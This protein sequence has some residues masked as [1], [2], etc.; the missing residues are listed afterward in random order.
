MMEWTSDQKQ[1]ISLRG[2]SLLVAAGAGSGKTAVLVERI[3]EMIS[4]DDP[5][6]IDSLLVVT[7]T[8]AA[9][10][11]MR[12]RISKRIAEKLGE[13]PSNKNL[14][15]QMALLNRANI[16]TMH[17][18]CNRVIVENFQSIDI[19]PENHLMDENETKLLM[20]EALNKVLEE[21]YESGNPDFLMVSD[22][23]GGQRDDKALEKL[24]VDLYKFAMAGPAP[25]EWIN[26][27]STAYDI[28][29]ISGEGAWWFRLLIEE[30]SDGIDEIVDGCERLLRA[31][32]N[33]PELQESK[34]GDFF[35]S[36]AGELAK[37]ADDLSDAG[38]YDGIKELL[39]GFSF[40]R[41]PIVKVTDERVAS[42]QEKIKAL[43]EYYKS[44]F[45]EL[46]DIW[47][48]ESSEYNLK[49]MREMSPVLK[50]LGIAVE[51]F[52]TVYQDLKADKNRMDYND[53][54]H[55][56]LKILCKVSQGEN[57]EFLVEP[58]EAALRY[59]E[60]FKEILVDEYQDSND[61]QET[62]IKAV[63]RDM[64]NVFMVGDVKQS[65]YRFRRAKPQLFLDKY[66][67]YS[68][69]EE[70]ATIGRKVMLFSNFRSRTE[71]LHAV[72][73]IFMRIMSKKAGELDYT[74]EEALTAKADY[75][76][77]K[78]I[79]VEIEIIDTTQNSNESADLSSE[80]DSVN[81]EDLSGLE[82][83]ALHVAS[84]IR[85]MVNFG[86]INVNIKGNVRP[87]KYKDIVILLRSTKNRSEVFEKALNELAIPV[88]SESSGGYFESI[89]IRTMLSL[90][91]T[92][93]NPRQDIPLLSVLR[94]PLFSFTEDELI[95]IRFQDKKL[96]FIDCLKE[97]AESETELGR[98]SAEFLD[99]LEKWRDEAIHMELDEFIWKLYSD[100]AYYEYAGAMP[101]GIQRQANLKILFQRAGNYE[102]TSFKGLFNFIRYIDMMQEKEGDFGD[103]K[104]FGENEDVVRI[105]SIHKSKGLEFPVVFLSNCGKAFNRQDMRSNILI[106]EGF[107][108]AVRN[109]NVEKGTKE[110]T[111]P[112][113]ILKAAL[114]R[115]S[116]SEEMR[117]LY[118]A[119]T[120]ARER[121]ILTGTALNLPK[122][123]EVWAEKGD[124]PDKKLKPYNVLKDSSY[125]DWIMPVILNE[126]SI[127]TAFDPD[128]IQSGYSSAEGF[129]LRFYSKAEVLRRDMDVSE[130]GSEEFWKGE[131]IKD[132]DLMELLNYEYP[133][134]KASVL[135]GKISVSVI[136]KKTIEENPEDRDSVNLLD[137]K[138]EEQ[139]VTLPRPTFLKE[140]K[141]LSGSERGTAFHTVM[142]HINP[143]VSNI[144]EVDEEIK[145]M[146]DLEILLKS[147]ADTVNRFKVLNFFKSD[148]GLRFRDADLE[149]NLYREEVFYRA[150]DPVIYDKD[151]LIDDKITMIGII[152]AFFFEGEDIVLLDYKTD[153][154]PEGKDDYLKNR[155]ESQ[156]ELYRIS[157]ENITG[158]RVKEAFLYSVSKEEVIR[159]I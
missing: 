60:R 67:S 128:E 38:T 105:M 113:N 28:E 145:R 100:T 130:E 117:V 51:K 70:E 96:L 77:D 79:P 106:H 7:F 138:Y 58:K 82:V 99:T 34:Y 133:D 56:A 9:A 137:E 17:S 36:E 135:P 95:S 18:F 59:R 148:L 66:L 98:K 136:K 71:I 49:L 45:K 81:D 92:I 54:E 85:E 68:L 116:L 39:S 13:D 72:N 21:C 158:K 83:E 149:G 119:M 52:I 12:E 74:E 57:G 19:D 109:I 53:L 10:T 46:K 94:S 150:I 6:D 121:L 147:E 123:L 111:L 129:N 48:K 29:E 120:R 87:L 75:D 156:I 69:P 32:E 144:E 93:D 76:Y 103:A 89:E 33:V 152:D 124:T 132:K 15:R 80:E 90:L 143:G 114:N 153:S 8:K 47:F 126:N 43:R 140:V 63:S 64:V 35:E 141:E 110:D 41:M 154:I 151:A 61:V 157:L 101:N 22:T 146:I 125:L 155:Y 27:A 1:A 14:I 37:L 2:E 108:I 127:K 62:I 55:F 23:L 25:K 11:E 118:V 5:I 4:G 42:E 139:E 86:D 26:K 91:R 159:M 88:Y 20:G 40:D 97:M 31:L 107:G 112:R 131:E 65:I 84:K 24:I 102:K 122:K 50:A 44:V 3:V 134:K 30:L 16:M 78:T 142:F 73:Y 115:E 104:I